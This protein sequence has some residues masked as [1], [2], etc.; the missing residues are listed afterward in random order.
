[1]DDHFEYLVAFVISLLIVGFFGVIGFAVYQ[2]AHLAKQCI[3]A[4][5]QY[6]DGE[7]K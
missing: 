4:G 1:M 6:D 2:D 3:T 5:K 7:C